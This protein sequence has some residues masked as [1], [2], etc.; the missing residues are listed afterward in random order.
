M[1]NMSIKINTSTSTSTSTNANTNKAVKR[2]VIHT[3]PGKTGTSA[4]Q[5]WLQKNQ[6]L[7]SKKGVYYP[8]HGL[9]DNGISSGNIHHLLSLNNQKWSVDADKVK[10]LLAIFE[11]R[12][13]HTLLLS[14]EFFFHNILALN[15]LMPSA[16]F[17]AYIRNP[18]ELLESNYNQSIKR[19]SVVKVFKAPLSMD[20]FLW[21][22][23]DRVFKK[24]PN[25]LLH[26]KAYHK[27]LFYKKNIISDF[28]LMINIDCLVEDVNVNRSFTFPALEYKRLLNNFD[29]GELETQLDVALQN[30]DIGVHQY[31]LFEADEYKYLTEQNITFASD[32]IAK[33]EQSQLLPLLNEWRN[34]QQKVPLK[35]QDISFKQLYAV[36]VFLRDK[37][38][39]LQQAL[40]NLISKNTSLVIDN[41]LIYDVFGV[42]VTG[43]EHVID[44]TLLAAVNKFPIHEDNKPKVINE[45]SEYF[46]SVGD[47]DN[48]LK[49]SHI[50]YHLNNK[51]ETVQTNLNKVLIAISKGKHKKI[52]VKRKTRMSLL[53]ATLKQKIKRIK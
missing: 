33:Y 50:A 3:G 25:E 46:L 52:P 31:S 11:K 17:V 6:R 26:L 53:K 8:K 24:V 30:C 28:L 32:F 34:T 40:A 42:D 51:L 5:A 37:Y 16:E 49:F 44:N 1:S 9:S 38:Q 36:N 18:V 29:L 47:V 14:S 43:S 2:I 7:L 13:E 12:S 4:I 27:K 48:A 21:G 45:L 20:N 10:T 41:Y 15:K 35:H 22:F 23:L 39:P 19:H